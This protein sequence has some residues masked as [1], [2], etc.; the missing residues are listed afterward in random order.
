[1][2]Y[3]IGEQMLF[4]DE[5]TLSYFREFADGPIVIKEPRV[6]TISIFT[7]IENRKGFMEKHGFTTIRLLDVSQHDPY[8][9]ICRELSRLGILVGSIL[10]KGWVWDLQQQK[11]MVDHSCAFWHIDPNDVISFDITGEIPDF[12]VSVIQKR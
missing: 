5:R 1:M 7:L 10:E 6:P 8:W 12:R 4:P 2:L 11:I 3:P 9:T